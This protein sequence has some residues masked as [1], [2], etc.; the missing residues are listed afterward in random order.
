MPGNMGTGTDTRMYNPRSDSSHLYSTE[1]ED[2]YKYGPGD[3]E[4]M[5]RRRDKIQQR[6]EEEKVK[7]LPHIKL[8]VEHQG[9]DALLPPLPLPG[10]EGEEPLMNEDEN[11]VGAEVSQL[12]GMP[13]SMGAQLDQAVGARTG[14]GSALGGYR[15]LLATG[16]PMD[17]AWSDIQK[18][19]GVQPWQAHSKFE[20]PPGGRTRQGTFTGARAKLLSRRLSRYGSGGGLDEAPQ[21]IGREHLGISVKQ[22]M[23]LFPEQYREYRGKQ[24]M[25][26]LHGNISPTSSAGHGMHSER[27]A[28]TPRVAMVPG[29]SGRPSSVM[30]TPK[31]MQVAKVPKPPNMFGKGEAEELKELLLKARGPLDYLH[32]SQ[33][34][35]MLRRVKDLMERK[36]SRLKASPSQGKGE[37]GHRDGGTTRPEGATEDLENDPKNWGAPSAHLVR[38][39]SGRTP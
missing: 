14:T 8:E 4:E 13:G 9:P 36:E 24:Q 32:F 21:A 6:K 3:A 33:L 28:Q 25:R 29:Q 16:E 17:W 23:K 15:P 37:A 5:E 35:S 7:D 30:A 11:A 27:G 22:P 20:G 18:R 12:T 19:H 38:Y 39:G 31:Q 2:D 1:D 34:R 26:R 10:P